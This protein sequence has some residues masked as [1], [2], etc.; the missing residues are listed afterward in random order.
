MCVREIA[1]QVSHIRCWPHAIK[2]T[3]VA[4]L[5]VIGL[6]LR[7]ADADEKPAELKLTLIASKS[8]IVSKV[9][10][11]D[12]KRRWA[13]Y[14]ALNKEYLKLW[15]RG[16]GKRLV[17]ARTRSV[18]RHPY[19]WIEDRNRDGIGDF[20]AYYPKKSGGNTQEFGAFF[21]LAD[22]GTPDWLVFYGGTLLGEGGAFNIVYW[23]HHV[24]DRNNDGRFDT[25]VLDCVDK[26]GDGKIEPGRT[27]W[28]Y[29][30]NFDGRIDSAQHIEN[31]KATKVPVVKGVFDSRVPLQTFKRMR[32]GA[33]FGKLFDSIARD[34]AGLL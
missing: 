28:F 22:D 1:R 30:T 2:T 24:I 14:A 34:I 5:L 21:D 17:Q 32:P 31:G 4:A 8:Q 13:I 33:P 3:A 20:Y 9:G 19:L 29:D 12:D 26:D 27:A 16:T 15:D 10:P 25:I 11:Y 7:P 6:G 18:P 23:N